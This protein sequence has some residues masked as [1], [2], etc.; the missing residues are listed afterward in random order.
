MDIHHPLPNMILW[1]TASLPDERYQNLFRKIPEKYRGKYIHNALCAWRRNL[2]DD[3]LS[4]LD[5]LLSEWEKVTSKMMLSVLPV[6]KNSRERARRDLADGAFHPEGRPGQDPETQKLI[7]EGEALLHKDAI[8]A[9]Q[10]EILD[11]SAAHSEDAAAVEIAS[12]C[13]WKK[14]GMLKRNNILPKS[15]QDKTAVLIEKRKNAIRIF[16]AARRL[17]ADPADFQ[18]WANEG[19]IKTIGYRKGSEGLVTLLDKYDLPTADEIRNLSEAEAH[20]PESE[21]TLGFW[22]QC[23][24]LKRGWKKEEIMRYLGG[25]DEEKINPHWKAGPPM[26]LY[27]KSRVLR[28]EEEGLAPA[29]PKDNVR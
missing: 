12:R 20:L 27:L 25:P 7:A 14:A 8:R 26:K 15:L 2:T 21:R 28:A 9:V 22:P 18:R 10:Q 13:D 3:E 4:V 11:Y 1:A 5:V 17:Y 24:L 16:D 23:S 19:K 29:K 6:S